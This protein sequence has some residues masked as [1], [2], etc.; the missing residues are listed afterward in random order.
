M[1][2]TADWCMYIMV[3]SAADAVGTEAARSEQRKRSRFLPA[4][5]KWVQPLDR[6]CERLQCPPWMAQTMKFGC[7]QMRGP[8]PHPLA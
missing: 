5:S 7:A 2:H 1:V 8:R 4:N 3:A 6:T